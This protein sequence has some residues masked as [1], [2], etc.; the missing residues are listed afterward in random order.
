MA[1]KPLLTVV[2]EPGSYLVEVHPSHPSRAWRHQGNGVFVGHGG[3]V[4]CVAIAY[5]LNDLIAAAERHEGIE[6]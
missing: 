2:L 1:D 4:R 3:K 5:A 6:R